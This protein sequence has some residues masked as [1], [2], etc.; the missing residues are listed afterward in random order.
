MFHDPQPSP[1]IEKNKQNK[2]KTKQKCIPVDAY[3]PQQ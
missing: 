1:P 3:H 2:T